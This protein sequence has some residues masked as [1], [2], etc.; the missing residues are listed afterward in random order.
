MKH[1]ASLAFTV[2]TFTAAAQ[3]THRIVADNYTFDPP[4]LNAVQGDSVRVI[5]MEPTHTF[6]QV[7]EATW[8]A[9]GTEFEGFYNFGPGLD[10][11]TFELV[12]TGIIYYVCVPH[13]DMGMKGIIDVG[14]AGVAEHADDTALLFHPNPANDRVWLS[15]PLPG[16]VSA[17]LTD[18]AG[19]TVLSAPIDMNAPLDV[20]ALPPGL[21]GVQLTDRTGRTIARRVLSIHR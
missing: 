12:G 17:R 19:R 1:L 21:Y 8:N 18:A 10:S 14:L 16:A 5:F 7:S 2:L 13:A 9:N 4:V 3:T 20:H 15:G 6:T 11:V